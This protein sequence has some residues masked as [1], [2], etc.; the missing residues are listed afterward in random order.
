MAIRDILNR[1][2]GT[3]EYVLHTHGIRAQVDGGKLS[4]RL[5]HFHLSL[6]P[7]LRLS[8][9]SRL[10]QE[11]A[12]ALGVL[13]CRLAQFE[14]EV[15]VEVPRPDPVPVRLLPLVQRVADV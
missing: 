6:P 11:L 4:P 9:L 2:A 15:Y 7:G 14:G 8:Q 3:I 1:Q 12:D 13:S 5:G 10:M